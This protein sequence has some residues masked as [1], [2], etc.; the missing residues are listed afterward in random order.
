MKQINILTMI[1]ATSSVLAVTACDK[2]GDTRTSATESQSHSTPTVAEKPAPIESPKTTPTTEESKPAPIEGGTIPTEEAVGKVAPTKP[3]EAPK[4]EK[5]SEKAPVNDPRPTTTP[6]PTPDSSGEMAQQW[7]DAHNKYRKMHGV[8]NVTW[9][10]EIAK[11]AEKFA[12]NCPQEHAET[13]YG[14]NMSWGHN[15]ESIE[16]VVGRWYKEE[17]RYDYQKNAY[18]SNAGHFS[19]LVWK[20]TTEIGCAVQ[21]NCKYKGN[22]YPKMYVCRYNPAGNMGGQFKANVLPKK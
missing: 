20:S 19:Q 3:K 6:P 16:D 2:N 14:E 5:T 8:P 15:G 12:K 4:S 13:E 1:V 21:T 11:S 7:V 10:A 17:S 22:T 9:S 18:Q